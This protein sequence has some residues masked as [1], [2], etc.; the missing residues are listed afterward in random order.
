MIVKLF[1]FLFVIF[2]SCGFHRVL[3]FSDKSKKIL[4]H[5]I[6][7]LLSAKVAK[8]LSKFLILSAQKK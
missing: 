8:I 1:S 2:E 5:I 6:V 3:K 4:I 7:Y